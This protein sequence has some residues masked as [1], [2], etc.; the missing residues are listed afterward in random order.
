MFQNNNQ[1]QNK[2][3]NNPYGSLYFGHGIPLPYENYRSIP[4]EQSEPNSKYLLANLAKASPLCCSSTYST[5][6]SSGGCVC[7]IGYTK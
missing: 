7:D 2:N 3:L 6:A 1:N 5:Y 4:I